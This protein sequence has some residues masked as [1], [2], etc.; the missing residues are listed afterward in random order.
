[1]LAN[2]GFISIFAVVDKQTG[3]LVE[4]PEIRARAYAEEDHVFDDI[5]PA[6]ERALRDA[7]QDG[8]RDNYQLQQ[9]I[10]KTVGSWVAKSHRRKPMI[11]PIVVYS[12]RHD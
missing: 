1:I 5:K 9:V 2:E 12:Y 3:E 6:I 7:A 8:V 4:G 11:F 10:R